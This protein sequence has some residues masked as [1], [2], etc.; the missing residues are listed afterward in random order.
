[1]KKYAM[2]IVPTGVGAE[3]GGYAGDANP[4]ARKL[5]KA[6]P[7]IV[8]PNVVNAAVFSG[9][10]ENMLYVEGWSMS[11]FVRGEISLLPHKNNKIGIIFDRAI[12]ENVLNIHI[13]TMNAVKTVYDVDI[14]GYE[15]TQES[16]GVEFFTS[17][18]GISTGTV[19]NPE[20]LLKAG[21]KL[22]EK[23]ADALAVV[24]FFEEPGEDDYENGAGVD[25]VGGIEGVISHYLSKNLLCPCAH[26]P[27]FADVEIKGDIVSPKVSAEYITPT[28]LPCILLG[29]QNAPLIRKGV[30]EGCLTY[31]NLHSIVM[32]CDSLGSA[33]VFDAVKNGIPVYAVREN[34]T[35]LEITRGAINLQNDIIEIDTYDEYIKIL[36]SG[37]EYV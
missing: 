3:H 32:P 37:E 20:T 25:I 15:I 36:Q 10:N 4:I 14:M 13:N 9:I 26:A 30:Q 28:F 35:V 29:L 12:P 21:K 31:K 34:K 11:G 5:S 23:G 27:A 6:V 1:M 8:N 33:V 22:L 7:L 18:S 2:M 19:K 24:A 17:E 16:A